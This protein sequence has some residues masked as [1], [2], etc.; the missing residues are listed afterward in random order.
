MWDH[1]TH[2]DQVFLCFPEQTDVWNAVANYVL[3]QLLQYKVGRRR[4]QLLCLA[5]P[6]Q[7]SPHS[8]G[9][10]AVVT[11]PLPGK[12]GTHPKS[13]HRGA[14]RHHAGTVSLVVGGVVSQGRSQSLEAPGSPQAASALTA[15]E[16][17]QKGKGRERTGMGPP[18]A[19]PPACPHP[20]PLPFHSQGV[21]IPT[22]GSFDI[23]QKRIQAGD[24]AMIFQWPVFHLATNLINTHHLEDSNGS[25]PGKAVDET[26]LAA[27]PG[28]VGH[29]L[30]AQKPSHG[31]SPKL[32]HLGGWLQQAARGGDA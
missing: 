8:S 6:S 27:R 11:L 17:F 25:L 3:Q 24:K 5:S 30:R 22:L 31:A 14:D 15:A 7:G 2:C 29:G 18:P 20:L 28:H 32:G 13:P 23:I 4:V 12:Q 16:R 21:R 19:L 1:Q 10:R 9:P 26:L